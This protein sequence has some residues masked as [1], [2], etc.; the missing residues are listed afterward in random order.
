M[1]GP[2]PVLTGQQAE[3]AGPSRGREFWEVE[4]TGWP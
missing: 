2:E 3:R 1:S 4:V